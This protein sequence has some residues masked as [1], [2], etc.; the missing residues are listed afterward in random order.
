MNCTTCDDKVCRKQQSSCN[1]ENFDKSEVIH[2][3]QDISTSEIVQAAAEL[4]DFGRA[5]QLSRLQ[6]II[7]FAKLMNYQR[8]G[9]AYCYG[10]EQHAKIL[11]TMLT[12]AGFTVAAVSCSVGG[13]KQS[14]VNAESCIHKVSCNPLAQAEQINNEGVDFTIT[15]GLCLGHDIIFQ[16]QIKSHTTTL[17]VKD[18][19]HNHNPIDALRN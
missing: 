11:E 5:G 16:K 18:R 17:V 19:V 1:R 2:E 9:I 14:E 12:D 4:V 3:Y 8:L 10:M 15:M 6:E 13:L 7:E